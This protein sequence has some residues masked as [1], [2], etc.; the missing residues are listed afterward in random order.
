MGVI[1]LPVWVD[2]VGAART[3]WQRYDLEAQAATVTVPTLEQWTEIM[4]PD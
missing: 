4:A 3:R 2:H 1:E